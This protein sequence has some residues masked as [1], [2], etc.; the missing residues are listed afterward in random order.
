MLGEI[1]TSRAR[2]EYLQRIEAW[3]EMAR[4]LAHEIKNPLTPIQLAVQDIHRRYS[5][6]DAEYSKLLDTAL[7][8]VEDEVGTLR[9]LVT[10]FSNFARL[11]QAELADADLGEFLEEQRDHLALGE[12]ER[13][14]GAEGDSAP[15]GSDVRIDF[16][17]AIEARPARVQMD[18]HM[19]RRALINLVRNAA[20]AI[21][22]AGR[23]SGTVRIALGREG[24]YWVVD[25]DD[26]G[27]GIPEQ[28][29]LSAFDP[30]VTTKLDGAGLGLAITKK[31]IVEHGGSITADKS[32]LGGARVRIRLPAPGTAASRAALAARTGEPPSVRRD[33]LSRTG[34]VG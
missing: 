1:E 14:E 16:Q 33:A 12:E 30:Y 25:V 13:L 32:D 9:R 27:P 17:L 8:I 4:R 11:P 3:Q 31:I 7:E 5:G 22:G 23:T 26:D 15:P 19:F 21:G 29:R 24:D 20:Q 28:M 2:I 6:Q 10:E 18:R 34:G